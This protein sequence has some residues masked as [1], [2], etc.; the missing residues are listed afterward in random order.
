MT[1]SFGFAREV[2]DRVFMFDDGQHT[3]VGRPQEVLDKPTQ[4][5][6]KAILSGVL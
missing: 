2:P 6:T 5:R 4:L 3:E 1:I